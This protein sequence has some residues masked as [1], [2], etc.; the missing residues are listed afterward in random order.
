MGL[1]GKNN[2]SNDFLTTKSIIVMALEKF[3]YHPTNDELTR[4]R[5]L[6]ISGYEYGEN[7]VLETIENVIRC[8]ICS[9]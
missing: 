8:S 4:C 2:S 6:K 1:I 7:A 9:F 5:R 3:P